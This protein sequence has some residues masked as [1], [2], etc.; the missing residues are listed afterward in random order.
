MSTLFRPRENRCVPQNLQ[1]L[2]LRNGRTGE[3]VTHV[4]SYVVAVST[5]QEPREC[6]SV[7]GDISTADPSILLL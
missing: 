4:Y 2:V 6:S 7:L 3:T 5:Q 1:N